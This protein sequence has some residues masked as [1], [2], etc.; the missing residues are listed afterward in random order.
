MSKLITFNCQVET[1]QSR[2]DSTLK[3][4]LGT[5]ELIEGGKLFALQNRLCTIGISQNEAL[6]KED[7]EL[8]QSSKLGLDDIPNAKSHSQR[9][10]N[11]LFVLWQQGNGGYDDFNMFYANRMD[12]LIE[13]IKSKLEQ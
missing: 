12:K 9:L 8:L 13:S 2:K 10:R 7:I 1:I 3:I 4:V 11:T 5:Q 6:T